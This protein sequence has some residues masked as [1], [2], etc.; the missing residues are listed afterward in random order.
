MTTTTPV[1]QLYISLNDIRPP[2]WRRVLVPASVT[3][4][5]LHTMLQQVMGWQDYHLH[6]FEIGDV[7]YGV[8][9][10]DYPE[11]GIQSEK[12][13]RLSDIAPTED[14]SFGYEYDFGDS[15]QHTILVEKIHPWDG[16]INYPVCI[17]GARACPPEDCGGSGG[18]ENFL[19]AIAD[20][21]HEEHTESLQWIGG[22]FD[23]EGFDP[24][25]VNKELRKI[26]IPV[27]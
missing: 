5:K 1:Y 16:K 20:P 9:D 15:W 13:V 14:S 21:D 3:L 7:S 18:Y 25:A 23:P 10:P 22:Y 2:I 11:L 19:E 26:P 8:P 17:G 6:V 4:P 24:N 12:R 27:P